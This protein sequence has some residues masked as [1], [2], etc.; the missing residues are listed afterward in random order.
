MS[1]D[2]GTEAPDGTALH[3]DGETFYAQSLSNAMADGCV[4]VFFR[5]AFSATAEN[6]WRRY[7]RAN[8]NEFDIPVYGVARDGPYALNAFIRDLDSPFVMFSDTNGTL[9]ESYGLLTGVD[10]MAGQEVARRAVLVV[11]ETREIRYR[12]VADDSLDAVSL[13]EVAEQVRSF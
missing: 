2:T 8:W 10:D 11:D 3:C 7:D 1:S 12:W 6:W 4:L 9:C 5:F 13:S